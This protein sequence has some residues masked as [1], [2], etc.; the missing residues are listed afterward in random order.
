MAADVRRSR[1][2]QDGGAWEPMNCFKRFLFAVLRRGTPIN[3][4]VNE[5]TPADGAVHWQAER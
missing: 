1:A 4:G 3:G 5:T 2:P